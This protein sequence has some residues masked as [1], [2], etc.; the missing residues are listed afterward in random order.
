[1][2]E[3]REQRNFIEQVHR[4]QKQHGYRNEE[5]AFIMQI[6]PRNYLQL[7]LEECPA[8]LTLDLV[9]RV[10]AFFE[11]RGIDLLQKAEESLLHLPE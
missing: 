5:M 6:S 10:A 7:G 9:A 1:M 11:V 2:L 4:L 8:H 3:E